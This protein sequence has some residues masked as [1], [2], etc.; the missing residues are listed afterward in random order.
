MAE[1]CCDTS[2]PCAA[3][4]CAGGCLCRPDADTWLV[5]HDSPTET[6]T[7]DRETRVVSSRAAHVQLPGESAIPA[8]HGIPYTL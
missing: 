2:R 1:S 8:L 3:C 6:S 4:G 5:S 7:E